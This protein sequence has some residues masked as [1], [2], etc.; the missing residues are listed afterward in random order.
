MI[1]V[2]WEPLSRLLG[3]GLEDLA[4]QHHEEAEEAQSIP[5]A[6][7]IPQALAMEKVG[8]FKIAAARDDG[9]LIGYA[10]FMITTPLHNARTKTAFCQG[11]F[12]EPEARGAAGVKLLRFINREM[13]KLNVKRTFIASKFHVHLGAAKK[14]ATLGRL[15]GHMGYQPSEVIH[16]R[17]KGGDHEQ[18][19]KRPD[20][21]PAD[22]PSRR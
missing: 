21:V 17:L 1:T 20:T 3:D 8:I 11:I 13:D 14:S 10:D 16:A 12:V 9:A 7:D 22:R 4:I 5:L 2:G 6:L 18:R 15:L 19:T